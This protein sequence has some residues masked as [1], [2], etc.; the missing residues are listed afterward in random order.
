VA[1]SKLAQ[2][3]FYSQ[4]EV[5]KLIPLNLLRFQDRQ[6]AKTS[7]YIEK[8]YRSCTGYCA[9]AVAVFEAR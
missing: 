5:P 7:I 8:L 3:G 4:S 9:S 2:T 1:N 6:S